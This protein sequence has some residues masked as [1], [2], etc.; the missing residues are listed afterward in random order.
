MRTVG[1]SMMSID[2]TR[3]AAQR[4]GTLVGA[5]RENSRWYSPRLTARW[6]GG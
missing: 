1:P 2:W 4:E 6:R 3:T 5:K